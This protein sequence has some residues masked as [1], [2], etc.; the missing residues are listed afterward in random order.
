MGVMTMG[1]TAASAIAT[2]Q[3]VLVDAATVVALVGF[4][5]TVAFAR[6]L[7]RRGHDE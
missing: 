2:D 3:P 1:M 6:Y 4:L 5:G 7:E